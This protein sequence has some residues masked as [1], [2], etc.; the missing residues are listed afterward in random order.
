M[1]VTTQQCPYSVQC[2]TYVI[3]NKEE[4]AFLH[5]WLAGTAFRKSIRYMQDPNS[6]VSDKTHRDSLGCECPGHVL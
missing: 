5:Q 4:I 1:T 2:P 6:K 3:Q